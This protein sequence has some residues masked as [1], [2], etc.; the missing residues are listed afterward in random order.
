MPPERRAGILCVLGLLAVGTLLF[1][2]VLFLGSNF[3]YRDLYAYHMP[4]ERIVHDTIAGGELPLWNRYLAGG[5]PLA[6]N[7][8]YEVFYPLQWLIFIGSFEFGYGLH[9]IVHVWLAL[10]GMY[11]L[12]R[13]MPLRMASSLFG[14]LSFGLSGLMLGAVANL[15]TFFVWAWAPTIGL[16]LLRLVR[17]PSPS[18]FALASLAAAMPLLVAEPFALI[19]LWF[20][21]MLAALAYERPRIPL[22][23]GA[24]VA[25]VAIAAV[26]LVPMFELVSHSS[27]SRGFSYQLVTDWSMSLLRPIELLA[28]RFFGL[29]PPEAH[30]LWGTH[31]FGRRGEPYLLSLYAGALVAILAMA[32]LAAR[33]RGA[34]VTAIAAIASYVLAIGGH[35]PL[36]A[37]LYRLGLRSIRYPEKFAAMGVIAFIVFA[38]TVANRIE[39]GD[40]RLQRIA[41][42]TAWIGAGLLVTWAIVTMLPPFGEWFIAM[43]SLPRQLVSLAPLARRV[44]IFAALI[45]LGW[46]G[47]LLAYARGHIRPALLA[48]LLLLLVD[49][50]SFANEA[51][52]RMP[53]SFFRQPEIVQALDRD[54]DDYA[55][56]QRG[57]R[58]Q[59]DEATRYVHM[60]GA[61]LA[62]NA[63]RPYVPA[64][65]HM[66]SVLEPDFD[67]TDLLVTRDLLD[68]MYRLANERVERWSEPFMAISNVRYV[69]DYRPFAEAMQEADGHPEIWRPVRIHRTPNQGRYWF[70][71]GLV[72]ARTQ[73]ELLAAFRLIPDVRGLAFIPWPP[74]TPAPARIVT[75]RERAND[76]ELDVE[77]TGRA[78]LVITVTR[79]THWQTTIDG[80]PAELLPANVAYQALVVPA[81]RHHIELHYRNPLITAG[82]IVSGLALFGVIVCVRPRRSG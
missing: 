77:S 78:L 42:L 16:T 80:A 38:A 3:Y 52:Q 47:I 71:R 58:A 25:A 34:R 69:L 6:A 11:A 20:L 44:A 51:A 7:P 50:G 12:L 41:L 18:R 55:I 82:T 35:T 37:I 27:R 56:F 62:R 8:A 76:A 33:V 39:G 49:L 10:I 45:A 28:P 19:Q 40:R 54:V 46:A 70:A 13:T 43:W 9:I 2:D 67:E 75:A 17:A 63:L 60:S 57:E 79:D 74:F 66:R 61:W 1:A 53:G 5:Q 64:L 68:A 22:I 72:P 30:A 32:G 31:V 73:D 48:G 15:P 26:Q 36:F 21:V 59:H 14:A 81:G 4:L 23:L 24:A 65:W 29:L